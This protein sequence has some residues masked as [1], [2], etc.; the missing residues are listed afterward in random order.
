MWD[1]EPYSLIAKEI[2]DGWRANRPSSSP[3]GR[4]LSQMQK[5]D[6]LEGLY[7]CEHSEADFE[8]ARIAGT[9]VRSWFFDGNAFEKTNLPE[10]VE[11]RTAIWTPTPVL[12]FCYR[13]SEEELVISFR[14]GPRAGN[15]H[16]YRIVEEHG[17]RRLD[18][19]GIGWNA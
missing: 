16:R 4:A 18:P 9:P 11:Q 3:A 10:K 15:G 7:V 14:A 17:Y 13:P 5:T 19:L 8:G 6:E 1:K 2:K 12:S